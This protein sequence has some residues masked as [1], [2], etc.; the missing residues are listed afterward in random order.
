V[1]GVV[2][3][4]SSAVA[5]KD[6]DWRIPT[7]PTRPG[8]GPTESPGACQWRLPVGS[9]YTGERAAA[10]SSLVPSSL[11]SPVTRRAAFVPRLVLARA[12]RG[13]FFCSSLFFRTNRKRKTR[14]AMSGNRT[15]RTTPPGTPGTTPTPESMVRRGSFGQ[16][17]RPTAGSYGSYTSAG[18]YFGEFEDAKAGNYMHH[19]PMELPAAPT[20]PHA[21]R[22][23]F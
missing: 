4:A 15:P 1:L 19:R 18:S 6:A 21:R 9:S 22:V 17:G 11:H 3:A 13:H 14:R 5:Q 2:T 10:H 7:P 20:L 8:R 12:S 23:A 16:G